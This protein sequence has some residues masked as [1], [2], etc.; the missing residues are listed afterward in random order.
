MSRLL[1]AHDLGTTGNKATIFSEEGK[2]VDSASHEY[3]TEYA[4]GGFVEQDPER[5]W[6][7]VCATTRQLMARHDPGRVAAISFSG[8]MM[9]CLCVDKNGVPLRKHI[10]YSD[11]RSTVQERVFR[12]KGGADEIY[13]I[14]GH[15]ASASYG[16]AKLMW[17]RDNQPD[18]YKK[19]HRMLNAKDYIIFRLGTLYGIGD[20][21]SRLRFDLVV[22]ILTLRAVLGETLTVFGGEQWRPIL[23]VRDV[24]HALEY[25]LD[26]GVRGLYNLAERNI[27]IS[28]LAG[29]ILH[30]VAPLFGMRIMNWPF[31]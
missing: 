7:S 17:V 3:P 27:E 22:N 8:Q 10:L 13:R 23:H 28:E 25:C 20:T 14:T 2:L 6:E 15:R 19:T 18:M 31:G 9:G 29:E 24:C 5:W 12:E 1:L 16:A 11:Q 21:H 30:G 26:H 4:P